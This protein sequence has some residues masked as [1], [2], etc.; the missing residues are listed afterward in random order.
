[1]APPLSLPNP[2]NRTLASHR[3]HRGQPA[4]A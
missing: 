3:R 4:Q 2:L 1:M